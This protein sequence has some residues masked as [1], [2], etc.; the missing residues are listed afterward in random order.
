M[1]KVKM[2]SSHSTRGFRIKARTGNTRV[3]VKPAP[4]VERAEYIAPS[5]KGKR[6]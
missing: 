4:K 6:S 5:K 2:K 1:H 3:A